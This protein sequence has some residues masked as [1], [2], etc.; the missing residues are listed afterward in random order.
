[1]KKNIF[2]LIE[3][4]VVIAIIAI[5]AAL[6]L[7]ALN[8]AREKGRSISCLSQLRQYGQIAGF[9]GDT[10]EDWNLPVSTH[11][12]GGDPDVYW[13]KQ[14]I[15]LSGG[16]LRHPGNTPALTNRSSFRCP[17]ETYP[18]SGTW[19][20]GMTEFMFTHYGIN[21]YLGGS[22]YSSGATLSATHRWRKRGSIK[23]PS[24]TVFI[25]D[26]P[27]RD[28]LTISNYMCISYRHGKYDARRGGAQ[29]TGMVP[30][31]GSNGNILYLDGHAAASNYSQM[32][33]P[34]SASSSFTAGYDVDSNYTIPF[35]P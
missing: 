23:T 7:P 35:Y 33:L 30:S 9:Y 20:T 26:S 14:L 13:Y 1:M 21:S 34:P 5:L 10:Y 12:Y 22:P 2:T 15:L 24:I 3:L 11:P 19:A 6:L 8:Q 31:P 29:L 17:S 28:T 27:A 25:T 32:K 16:A 4:L 18:F